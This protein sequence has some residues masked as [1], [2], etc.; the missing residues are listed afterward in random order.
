MGT[1]SEINQ[2]DKASI[3]SPSYTELNKL[4]YRSKMKICIQV[5]EIGGLP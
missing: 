3:T 4:N 5:A 1:L 2:E